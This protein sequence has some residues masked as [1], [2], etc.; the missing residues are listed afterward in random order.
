MRMPPSEL[1]K[2]ELAPNPYADVNANYTSNP[3][4]LSPFGAPL[5]VNRRNNKK[6]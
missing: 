6:N 2:P 1:M 3:K 5:V 4:E